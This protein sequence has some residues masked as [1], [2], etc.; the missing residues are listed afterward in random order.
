MAKHGTYSNY[1]K[2]QIRRLRKQ[3]KKQATKRVDPS[4]SYAKTLASQNRKKRTVRSLIAVILIVVAACA[5][6]LFSF[7]AIVNSRLSTGDS[8]ASEAL[9]GAEDGQPVYT[10]IRVDTGAAPSVS[11]SY[12]IK[13]NT[14]IYVL[15]R[16]DLANSMV[17]Y[18]V[19]PTALAVELSDY[20]THALCYAEEL[21]GDAELV[22]AVNE[23]C[24]I[25]LNHI[26]STDG[27]ALASFVESMGGL[28]LTLEY[29]LDDP[30]ASNSSIPAGIIALDKDTTLTLLRTRNVAGGNATISANVSNFL[31][32]L[33]NKLA[34][35]SGFD[36][37][38]VVS[39]F[40]E[41]SSS[42]MGA[43]AIIDFV[44]KMGEAGDLT[45]YNYS[46]SGAADKSVDTGEDVFQ[47]SY[48]S[49]ETV[50]ERFRSGTDPYAT[51]VVIGAVDT[52][53]IHV[54]VRNGAEILGAGANLQERLESWGYIVD[55]V[56]NAE[57]GIL[58]EET[59]VIYFDDEYQDAANLICRE[60]G[61]GRVINGGDYYS[62]ESNII[63]IIGL[64]WSV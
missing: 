51:D 53:S 34:E 41:T 47:S 1:S 13:N 14:E 44:N 58:Y 40:A 50:L 10:L 5:I 16:T 52:A 3:Q 22:R 17:S 12:N 15:M 11:A 63:V 45:I 39:D 19:I 31:T 24:G 64:D 38:G 9:A 23:F 60:L 25:E 18:M 54:E 26:I 56:G 7:N 2:R 59:F 4:R 28:E 32:A 36:L 35:H 48:S 29:A 62:S 57:S 33:I 49:T 21:G 30:Y 27:E 42:D 43:N 6:G 37:A 46:I 61:V 55:S 8:N 20:Q